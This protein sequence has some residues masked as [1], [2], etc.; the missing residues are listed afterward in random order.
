MLDSINKELLA[1][2]FERLA[3]IDN[4]DEFKEFTIDIHVQTIM[5]VCQTYL[6]KEI[7]SAQ[8]IAGILPLLLIPAAD[9]ADS[10]TYEMLLNMQN[11]LNTSLKSDSPE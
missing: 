1:E 6:D 3:V 11:E 10:I 9:S 2:K 4:L 5:T 7:N 8:L